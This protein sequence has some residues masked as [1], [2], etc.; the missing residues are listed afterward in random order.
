MA[1]AFDGGLVEGPHGKRVRKGDK[2]PNV[3]SLDCEKLKAHLGVIQEGNPDL[4][5]PVCAVGADYV[6][7]DKPAGIPSHPLSLFDRNTIT[8]WAFARFPQT[9]DEFPNIQPTITPHRLD[10]GTSGL[11]V[12]ALT[13]DSFQRWRGA[14]KKKK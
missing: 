1:E 2:F 7:I 13:A 10:T 14:F 8:H 9:R 5:V 4:V 11:L 6:V 3:N 12:V